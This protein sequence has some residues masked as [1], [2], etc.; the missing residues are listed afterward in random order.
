M[1]TYDESA[2]DAQGTRVPLDSPT[3]VHRHSYILGTEEA[4]VTGASSAGRL[5]LLPF[6]SLWS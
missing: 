5:G 3:Y 6:T 2:R 1:G 4:G